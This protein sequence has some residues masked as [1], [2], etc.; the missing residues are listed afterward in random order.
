[1]TALLGRAALRQGGGKEGRPAKLTRDA[2]TGKSCMPR[3]LW[4]Q[5]TNPSLRSRSRSHRPST[6]SVLP[7]PTWA[8][9][10]WAAHLHHTHTQCNPTRWMATCT[11][12]IGC[13]MQRHTEWRLQQH[14]LRN[15]RC[16]VMWSHHPPS[17]EAVEAQRQAIRQARKDARRAGHHPGLALDP[18]G[19]PAPV[20]SKAMHKP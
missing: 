10:A 5:L 3:P 2:R 19:L 14:V 4:P 16:A 9:Q 20:A 8:R 13:G 18:S 7:L 1:M 6:P 17:A 12:C 15:P 11:F